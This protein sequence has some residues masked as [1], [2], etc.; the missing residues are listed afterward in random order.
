LPYVSAAAFGPMVQVV[1]DAGASGNL[2]GVS[3]EASAAARVIQ[4]PNGEPSLRF[5]PVWEIAKGGASPRL[6]HG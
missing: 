4:P 3:A 6:A 1:A 2:S 5:S